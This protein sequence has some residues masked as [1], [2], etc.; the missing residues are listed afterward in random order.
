MRGSENDE[1]AKFAERTGTQ[2]G[3]QATS[4]QPLYQRHLDL[5]GSLSQQ[6]AEPKLRIFCICAATY[7][8]E[9]ARE[10]HCMRLPENPRLVARDPV[11][12]ASEARGCTAG[13]HPNLDIKPYLE[14]RRTRPA[15]GSVAGELGPVSLSLPFSQSEEREKLEHWRILG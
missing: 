11:S 15:K 3:K 6:G 14:D 5:R 4:A 2:F 13:R 12:R 7:L 8:R 9:R 10:P 1:R